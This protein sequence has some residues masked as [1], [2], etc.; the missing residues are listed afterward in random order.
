MSTTANPTG[1]P[2]F[3]STGV[4]SETASPTA[5]E[6][7]PTATQTESPTGKSNASMEDDVL[8]VWLNTF[9]T[10]KLQASFESQQLDLLLEPPQQVIPQELAAPLEAQ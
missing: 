7:T 2:T 3:V 4:G 1:T 9:T 5:T 8:I 10:I 6:G